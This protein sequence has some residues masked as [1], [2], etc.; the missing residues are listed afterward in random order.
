MRLELQSE[1]EKNKDI[2]YINGLLLDGLWLPDF[3]A[4]DADSKCSN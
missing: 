3:P 4:T 1:T 2:Q